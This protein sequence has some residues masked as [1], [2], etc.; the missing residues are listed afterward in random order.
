[1]TL[2]AGTPLSAEKRRRYE[3]T[4]VGASGWNSVGVGVLTFV[5]MLLLDDWL[6]G[7]T[8][9]NLEWLASLI[10]GLSPWIVG[11]WHFIH[12]RPHE[13]RLAQ[14]MSDEALAEWYDGHQR[15][16]RTRDIILVAIALG[17]TW[18]VLFTD[19][20]AMMFDAF[21]DGFNGR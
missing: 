2:E 1:M 15:T 19:R 11:I 12:E 6:V 10:L 20:G 9:S 18:G 14:A 8:P 5:G 21:M 7:L 4:R 3:S 16:T 17:I 13:K